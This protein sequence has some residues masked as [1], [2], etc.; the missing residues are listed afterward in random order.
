MQ[1]WRTGPNDEWKRKVKAAQAREAV[2]AQRELAEAL[3]LAR[4]HPDDDV[5]QELAATLQGLES[6]DSDESDG[7]GRW[8]DDDEFSDDTE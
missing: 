5:L 6:I 3:A 1:D 7:S 2:D 8:T 4:Q